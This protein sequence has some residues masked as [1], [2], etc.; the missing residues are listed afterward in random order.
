[1]GKIGNKSFESAAQHFFYRR[2]SFLF[3]AREVLL[4][5]RAENTQARANGIADERMLKLLNEA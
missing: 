2:R 4:Q 5:E 3:I 1:L